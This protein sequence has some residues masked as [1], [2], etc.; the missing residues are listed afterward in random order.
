MLLTCRITIGE[1]L[2][3]K[4][5]SVQIETSMRTLLDTASITIPRVVLYKNTQNDVSE[6]RADELFKV[7]QSV[8]IELG[9]DYDFRTEFLGFVSKVGA[10]SLCEIKCECPM[11]QLKK[12]SFVQSWRSVTLKELLRTIIP[13]QYS[14]STVE[15]SLGAFVL[16]NASAYDALTEL[17]NTYGLVSYF[18]NGVLFVG[19]PYFSPGARVP[20]NL[21]NSVP[22]DAA[23]E[24]LFRTQDERTILIKAISMQTKGGKKE[25]EVGDKNGEVHTIHLPVNLS[26]SE[27]KQQAEEKLKT[28]RFDGYEGALTLFGIPF[29]QHSDVVQIAD[30]RYPER[31][32]AYFVESRSV[33]FGANGYRANCKLGRKFSY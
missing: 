18:R 11:W 7:G 15:M 8:K 19:L 5:V 28:L 1:I 2:L 31:A 29:I 21:T 25:V 4:A 22:A 30:E 10:D 9:Y 33:A 12:T 23:N 20:I 13:N 3:T 27:L 16:K 26:E 6:S 24:L 14:V 32:G 17:K